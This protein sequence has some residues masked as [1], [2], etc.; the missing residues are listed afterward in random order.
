MSVSTVADLQACPVLAGTI[1]SLSPSTAR[2]ASWSRLGTQL[3]PAA[4]SGTP[5]AGGEALTDHSTSLF[6]YDVAQQVIPV[7]FNASCQ[8]NS[9]TGAI[10][11]HDRLVGV[12]SIDP[13]TTGDKD[14]NSTALTRYTS[15][16]D[17]QVWV[18]VQVVP[19]TNAIV[20]SLSSY[21]NQN[22]TGGRAGGTVTF[23]TATLDVGNLVG[24]MP[25]QSGDTGV[26]SVETLNIA[27]ASAGTT[28][29]LIVWLIKPYFIGHIFD[30][31]RWVEQQMPF[32]FATAQM[33][34]DGASIGGYV[35]GYNGQES[36]YIDFDVALA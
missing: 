30:L 35:T 22:G 14:V 19:S 5:G 12:G 20:C 11:L 28:A 29:R 2:G 32:P 13:T 25:L 8:S 16:E 34:P 9:A 27:T 36:F 26:R 23:P 33:I 7:R 21:T 17:V 31:Q 1:L 10:R 3:I 15:G 24:P 6:L 18:E 4:G